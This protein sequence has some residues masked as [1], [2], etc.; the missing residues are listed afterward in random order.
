[1]VLTEKS[2]KI[3]SGVPEH[4]GNRPSWA[5]QGMV[6]FGEGALRV[7]FAVALLW[8]LSKGHDS[9]AALSGLD[10]T[11]LA[12][13]SVGAAMGFLRKM[14]KP[15]PEIEQKREPDEIYHA[16]FHGAGDAMLIHPL[17]GGLSSRYLDVNEATCRLLKYSREELLELTPASVLAFEKK[18]DYTG[19]PQLLQSQ[20]QVTMDTVLLTK[21]MK[22]VPVRMTAQLMPFQG[23][24][25]VLTTVR[26]LS[27]QQQS[28]DKLRQSEIMLNALMQAS[29]L[30]IVLFD[31]SGMISAW[32]AAAERTFGYSEAEL[33]GKPLPTISEKERTALQLIFERGRKG[34]ALA[35]T[36]FT[37]RHKNLAVVEVNISA[38]PLTAPSGE[39]TGILSVLTDT[40][41][42]SQVRGE[43]E[44]L[45]QKLTVLTEVKRIIVHATEEQELLQQVC[46]SLVERG[47]YT[48]AWIGFPENNAKKTITPIVF[49]GQDGGYLQA[50]KFSWAESKQGQDPTG[51][52]IQNSEV[53]VVRDLLSNTSQY[54][55]LAEAVSRGFGSVVALPLIIDWRPQAALTVYSRNKE[56]FDT[57]EIEQ[58]SEIADDL[59][60]G[61]EL[62]RM[63]EMRQQTEAD[64]LNSA[65]EWRATFD[66]I[67]EPVC[68]IN[69]HGK[70]IRCNK[71]TTALLEKSFDDIIG[72]PAA[73]VI[74]GITEVGGNSPLA[75]VRESHKSE[76][77]TLSLNHRWY[78]V[79]VDPVFDEEGKLTG[80]THIMSDITAKKQAE[81][82]R[83][84][85]Y[86]QLQKIIDN[87]IAAIAK[88]VELRDP[89]TAGHEQQVSNL[90]TR[91]AQ[92]MGLSDEQVEG[93]RVGGMLHDIGKIYVPAELLSKPGVLSEI[94]F[95]LIKMH[96]KAGKDIL[97]TIDFPWR[98]SDM[99]HQHH[100]RMN[101]SGYP[102]GYEGERILLEA[103]ILAVADVVESMASHRPYRKARG[104]DA[105]LQ[106]VTS[107]AGVLYDKNVVNACVK[108]FSEKGF[109]FQ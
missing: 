18:D 55:W 104:I 22:R 52:A 81:E 14:T 48:L 45:N 89:Y 67:S 1:M 46:N 79:T 49:A 38:M 64:L 68:V 80:A 100:E 106:E 78:E 17:A 8:F 90:A 4:S 47:G 21:D 19:L 54:P 53:T 32:N 70:I 88:I 44:Q 86:N 11:T 85:Y 99:A 23:Q 9:S 83:Q 94:E 31:T 84:D 61:V 102:S 60:Y 2:L 82:R 57:A 101:G 40:T 97:D 41:E 27:E 20:P 36:V 35:D 29:P 59:R 107:K 42:L 69:Q 30:A 26:D 34:E 33:V 43:F 109:S 5:S 37:L 66:A 3:E 56:A 74:Y 39:V 98:I 7:L 13:M 92:E 108:L 62:L 15:A 75:R 95:E 87:T 93:V 77:E 103:R 91:I 72:Q 51:V 105:A 76:T 12:L 25:A 6:S 96:P 16:L 71:A 28:A 50:V 58:L 73:K 10:E 24:Q 65:Q 63:R